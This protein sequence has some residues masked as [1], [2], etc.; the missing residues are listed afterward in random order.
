[1]PLPHGVRFRN[2]IR[3]RR[4][5]LTVDGIGKVT[6]TTVDLDGITVVAGPNDTGKSTIGKG[7]V[8]VGELPA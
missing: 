6:D 2:A 1:M 3:R 7:A 5:R 4:M 8:R